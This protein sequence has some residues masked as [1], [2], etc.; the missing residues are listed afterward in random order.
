MYISIH[1]LDFAPLDDIQL[2]LK[3]NFFQISRKLI[4]EDE[5]E[6]KFTDLE[7]FELI[8]YYNKNQKAKNNKNNLIKFK[9][10]VEK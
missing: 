5:K 1:C 7:E 10:D 3:A 4:V 9:E 6:A 8:E 2:Q